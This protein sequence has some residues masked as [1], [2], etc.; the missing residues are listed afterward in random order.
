MN[1]IRPVVHHEVR[2][3]GD[4]RVVATV[5]LPYVLTAAEEA[6]LAEMVEVGRS[7]FG[8]TPEERRCRLRRLTEPGS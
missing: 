4:G 6:Q 7:L 5:C 1:G 2:A 8:L 3:P